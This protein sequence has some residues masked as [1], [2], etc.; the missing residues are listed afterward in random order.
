MEANEDI[1]K[2]K[3]NPKP[4][5][6]SKEILNF[7]SRQKDSFIEW[8]YVDPKLS[9]SEKIGAYFIK[10]L[11]ILGVIALS[12]MLLLALFLAFVAAL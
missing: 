1:L 3:N 7:L 4:E 8:L 5:S 10:F 9:V 11:G 6:F 2:N 12:P